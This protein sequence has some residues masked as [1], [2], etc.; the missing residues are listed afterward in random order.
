MKKYTKILQKQ[1]LNIE[2]LRKREREVVWVGS[3]SGAGWVGCCG[4]WGWSMDWERK[5]AKIITKKCS[6]WVILAKTGGLLV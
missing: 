2:I 5:T 6:L 1:E 3:D 4:G